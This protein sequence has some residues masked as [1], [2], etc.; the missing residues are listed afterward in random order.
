[1]S[2]PL[3]QNG[4][5][6]VDYPSI[7]V[8]S[9][10]EAFDQVLE[11]YAQGIER[12]INSQPSIPTWDDLVL[13]MDD[14]DAQVYAVLYGVLPLLGRGHA[15]SG[16]ILA[17][18]IAA[19]AAL[20]S[21]FSNEQLQSL[22]EQLAY[23]DIGVNLDSRQRATLRWHLERFRVSG[24]SLP[25]SDKARLLDLQRRITELEEQYLINLDQPD[26]IVDDVT[27]LRGLSQRSLDELSE[28]ARQ[29][30]SQGW[31]IPCESWAAERVLE[32]AELGAI[33]EQVFRVFHGRGVNTGSSQDNG[34]VLEQLA[35]LRHE[36]ATLL[37]FSDHMTLSLARKSAGSPDQVRAFLHSLAAGMKPVVL[38]W[39]S[40]LERDAQE[41]GLED[42]QPWDLRFAQKRLRDAAK[43]VS[44][45]ALREFFPMA[46]V[47]D[48]LVQLAKRLFDLELRPTSAPVWAPSVQVFEAFQDEARIG[49][50]Y[51]DAVQHADKQADAVF[52]TYVRNRRIDA[53][54]VY[55][56]AV[57]IVF[58]DV[59]EGS[60]GA[61][62]LLDHLALRKLF[63]EFGH[64][65][66]HLL[67]RTDNQ[68]QSGVVELGTDGME[69]FGKLFE[70]WVWNAAYVVSISSHYSDG[71]QIDKEQVEQ[72]IARYKREAI[73]EA[74]F[75]LSKA[76]FDVDLH[77]NPSDGKTLRQRFEQSREQC[78]YW[79]LH[80]DE[81]PA[82]AFDHLV[83]G[84]DAGYYAYIWA[85]VCAV[86]I[87]TRFEQ[88][89]LF[90]RALGQA[91]FESLIAPG[92][93]RP[94][95]EGVKAFLGRDSSLNPY[96][97]WLQAGG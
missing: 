80:A 38:Q 26:V 47:I 28:R 59:P 10:Q 73:D 44:K 63:H 8:E 19:S 84:Y 41:L 13:A 65:L 25:T 21:R 20:D 48:A 7:T 57:V 23:G 42:M 79:P 93:S 81:H 1:M 6:S 66:H 5:V 77:T 46:A 90:D 35:L 83:T 64:A 51:L 54:G 14:L 86:D 97:Q 27:Q 36:R 70:R 67:V 17:F 58:S 37:A 49:L 12:V 56:Q 34:Q 16:P 72:C 94:L 18:H 61:Q 91:L 50:L 32:E 11:R 53:E 85:D 75:E 87:F 92:A 45:E 62:P 31:S 2:N 68:V 52:T 55:Q 74:A 60:A 88:A 96:L 71:H 76:L 15:W 9:M 43:V 95:R 40:D 4:N 82:H 69:L 24:A 33:R 89:G 78:G 29:R 30:G 39:R 22:Y 3:L